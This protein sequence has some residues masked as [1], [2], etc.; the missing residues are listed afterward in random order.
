MLLIIHQFLKK[1][2]KNKVDI[3]NVVKRQKYKINLIFRIR[4]E[5]KKLKFILVTKIN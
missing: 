4:K 2:I 3:V 5:C 1:L